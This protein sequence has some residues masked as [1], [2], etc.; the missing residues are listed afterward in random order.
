M[1]V[2]LW[3]LLI[4]QLFSV[5]E[6]GGITQVPFTGCMSPKRINNVVLRQSN[7]DTARNVKNGCPDKVMVIGD[8]RAFGLSILELE[9]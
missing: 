2:S 4:F 6:E 9:C 8:P 7:V 5:F 1:N 3:L